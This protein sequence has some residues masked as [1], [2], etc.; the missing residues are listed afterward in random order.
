MNISFLR[1]IFFWIYLF[2]D[3]SFFGY[4]LYWDIFIFRYILFLILDIF[5]LDISIQFLRELYPVITFLITDIKRY[6]IFGYFQKNV[7]FL[8]ILEKNKNNHGYIQKM[9]FWI[10]P[11]K[12]ILHNFIAVISLKNISMLDITMDIPTF[13]IYQKI[14]RGYT[15]NIQAYRWIFFSHIWNNSKKTRVIFEFFKR[16]NG[17]IHNIH[18]YNGYE[19]V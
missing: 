5:F 9:I 18:G 8:D 1:Y 14:F 4:I 2:L 17:Y 12:D 16:Y 19:K 11:Q 10:Y 7:Y 3:I 13:W 15:Q 6:F